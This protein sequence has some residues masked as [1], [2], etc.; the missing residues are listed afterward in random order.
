MTAAANS[1]HDKKEN[2]PSESLS[3][4]LTLPF[5]RTWV[6]WYDN[7]R[8]AVPDADWKDNLKQC[9]RFSSAN[10][11]W[12]VF[13]NVLPASEIA[14]GSNYHLFR[15]NVQPMWEDPANINGGKFVL[16][17]PKKDSKAGKCDEWWLFTVL[18]V[19]G[20][21]MDLTGD[22]ICGAVVSIRKSQDRIALWLKSCEKDACVKIG[23]RWKRALEVSSKTP[24]K[25]QSHKDGT[26]L[27]ELKHF[28]YAPITLV[29]VATG[30]RRLR[31]FF[32]GLSRSFF[33][34][35]SRAHSPI[36]LYVSISS[37]LGTMS[38]ICNSRCEW[39]FL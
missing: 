17:M 34:D 6:L 22:E 23:A 5:H 20:E 19:I 26:Y 14:P 33:H 11:F 8:F 3:S 7:P 9:G 12:P 24:L 10:D 39:E 28:F 36:T 4:P 37:D 29:D 13:N 27:V 32:F 1:S 31:V 38:L 21:T 25:Y 30:G 18:A 2:A 35:P 16:A 15:D